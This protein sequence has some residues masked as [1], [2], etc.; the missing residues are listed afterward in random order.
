MMRGWKKGVGNKISLARDP[1][2][3]RGANLS[4]GLSESVWSWMARLAYQICR[5]ARIKLNECGI[6]IAVC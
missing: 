6:G 1:E 4:L 2:M 5:L 3:S